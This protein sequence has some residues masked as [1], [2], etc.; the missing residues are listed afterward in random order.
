LREAFKREKKI[1]RWVAFSD[2]D[3]VRYRAKG[4]RKG[5][6][7]RG[8]KGQNWEDFDGRGEREIV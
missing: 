1:S 7:R 6:G 4:N 5:R 3:W 2:S 8:L